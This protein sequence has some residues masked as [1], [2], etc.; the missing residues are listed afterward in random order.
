MNNPIDEFVNAFYVDLAKNMS[1]VTQFLNSRGIK[2]DSPAYFVIRDMFTIEEWTLLL[3]FRLNASYGQKWELPH[4]LEAAEKILGIKG[5]QNVGAVMYL[6]IG[7]MLFEYLKDFIR[8]KNDISEMGCFYV[9]VTLAEME[10]CAI[11]IGLRG[12]QNKWHSAAGKKKK[13]KVSDLKHALRRICQLIRSTS[14]PKVKAVLKDRGKI[15]DLYESTKDPINIHGF[16]FTGIQGDRREERKEDLLHY[17]TRNNQ[18]K[19]ILVASVR[20]TLSIIKKENNL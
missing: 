17:T 1:R 5:Y 16:Q 3:R 9:A 18:S 15:Q 6:E 8:G 20:K 2:K 14:W 13:G 19:K 12:L 11:A 7:G 4:N 10:M